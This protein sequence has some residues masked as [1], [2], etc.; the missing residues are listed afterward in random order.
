MPLKK[1][2]SLPYVLL[3]ATTILLILFLIIRT[4]RDKATVWPLALLVIFLGGHV[5]LIFT[6]VFPFQ[7]YSRYMMLSALGAIWIL[8][9]HL[10]RV[11]EKARFSIVFVLLV[12]FIPS[13]IIN[14]GAYKTKAA[15]WQR[16]SKSFPDDE[17]V[18]LQRARVHYES[19]DYLSAEVALNR[20][21]TLQ[22]NPLTAVLTSLLYA[23]IDMTRSKYD[24]VLRWMESIEEF[25]QDRDLA[26]APQIRYFENS[27]TAKVQVSRGDFESAEKLLID[28]VQRYSRFPEA[29]KELYNLYIGFQMWDK[30]SALETAMKKT[31]PRY[32]GPV[33]TRFT[34]EQFENLPLDKKISFYVLGRDFGRAVEEVQKMPNPDIDHRIFLA[35]LYY[36]Q[37]KE[38]EGRQAI[39]SI[40]AS[41]PNNVEILNKIG[42][43]YL[44]E[45][46]R[47]KEAMDYFDRSLSLN[48]AQPT[49]LYL[50]TQ[51]KTD[52]LNRLIEVWK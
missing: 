22:V 3:G 27:K 18:L 26:I 4:K 47:V 33:D 31:Y 30:A 8:A 48:P 14:A 24:N 5:A 21:L 42:N 2:E 34:Q 12:L 17:H 1:A 6:S 52:Y 46:F 9:D 20:I 15:F 36:F 23:D 39:G 25:E 16:A 45:L 32:F 29:Y 35:K 19:S 13:I 41:D 44:S 10:S 7:I 38:D 11:K 37:G 40:L 51:L 50:T 49:L 43:C 28:N